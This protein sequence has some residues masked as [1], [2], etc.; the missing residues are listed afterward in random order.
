MDGT[1]FQKKSNQSNVQRNEY[2]VIIIGRSKD[3]VSFVSL[4]MKEEGEVED[5]D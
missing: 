2:I 4:E 5:N 1:G 3:I